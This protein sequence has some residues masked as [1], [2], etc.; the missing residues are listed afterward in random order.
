M[1]GGRE[2]IRGREIPEEVLEKAEEF[3][4]NSSPH[5]GEPAQVMRDMVKILSLLILKKLERK[6]WRVKSS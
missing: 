2:Q 5:L 3:L 4:A 1:D 6:E